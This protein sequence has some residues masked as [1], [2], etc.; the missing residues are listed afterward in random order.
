[1]MREAVMLS[2]FGFAPHSL[3]SGTS[4]PKPLSASPLL[5]AP[6]GA[7]SGTGDFAG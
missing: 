5:D 6:R 2:P 4:P 3:R 7:Q 1:M